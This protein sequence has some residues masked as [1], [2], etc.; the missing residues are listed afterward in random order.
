VV[1]ALLA[2][3][4]WGASRLYRRDQT[5]EDVSFTHLQPGFLRVKHRAALR[6]AADEYERVAGLYE[7]TDAEPDTGR[8]R[9]LRKASTLREL[10]DQ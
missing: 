3:T 7:L 6:F 10:A 9:C 1:D 5:N 2:S 8:E 4:G